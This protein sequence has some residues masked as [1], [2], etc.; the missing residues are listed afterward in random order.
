VYFRFFLLPGNVI[1]V[2]FFLFFRKTGRTEEAVLLEPKRTNKS[3]FVSL[4][5]VFLLPGNVINVSFFLFLGKLDK[6]TKPYYWN[7]NE[8]T[9]VSSFR[10]RF[11]LLPG[12]VIN[13]PF[14]LFF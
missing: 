13:V 10:F 6:R 2:P 14:F 9:K 5:S 1:N 7:L 4:F 8:R 12:N 3:K 11:F